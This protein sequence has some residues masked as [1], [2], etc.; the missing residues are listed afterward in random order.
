MFSSEASL[1]STELPLREKVIFC[2][3]KPRFTLR[4]TTSNNQATIRLETIRLETI[5]LETIQLETI[6]KASINLVTVY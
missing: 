1:L 3:N 6:Q 2:R 4:S 5:R